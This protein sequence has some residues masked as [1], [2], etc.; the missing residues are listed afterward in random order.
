MSFDMFYKEVSIVTFLLVGLITFEYA[1]AEESSM[2]GFNVGITGGYVW[3]D[4]DTTSSGDLS[5]APTPSLKPD[6]SL[7]GVQV[8]Y[9]YDFGNKFVL[10]V[11]ADYSNLNADDSKCANAIAHCDGLRIYSK[12]VIDVDWL[13]TIR[14]KLG[15]KLNDSLLLYATGGVAVAN[16]KSTI[17]NIDGIADISEKQ[18]HI[19][20]AIGLGADYRFTQHISGG[21]EYLYVDLGKEKYDFS[22]DPY[23]G[24]YNLASGSHL[25]TDIQLDVLKLNLQYHF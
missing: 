21:L 22:G 19:G 7:W 17:T 11:V 2:T 4:S 12:D 8:G 10:G 15:Y 23:W 16:V 13:S 9:D 18:R 14:G 6:G 5:D 20:Y 3:G 24:Y 1:Q 25:K